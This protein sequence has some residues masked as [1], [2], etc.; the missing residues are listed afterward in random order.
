MGF[1][2]QALHRF[3]A[4]LASSPPLT[5]QNG[6]S[7]GDAGAPAAPAPPPAASAPQ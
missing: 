1:D 4:S 6:A 5:E 3:E 7:P 2:P